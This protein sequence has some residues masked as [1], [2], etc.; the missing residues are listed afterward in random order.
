MKVQLNHKCSIQG[1]RWCTPIGWEP[2]NN[3]EAAEFSEG[4]WWSETDELAGLVCFTADDEG[5][6]DIVEVELSDL[7][8]VSTGNCRVIDDVYTVRDAALVACERSTDNVLSRKA[9]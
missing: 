2:S 7:R 1:S 3:I 5:E 4:S 9:E 8:V 6:D